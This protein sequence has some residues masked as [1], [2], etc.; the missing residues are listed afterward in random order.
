MNSYL[1][2]LLVGDGTLHLGKNW[3]YQVWID[4]H[5]KNSDIL[6]KAV[7]ILRNDGFNVWVYKVPGN[8]TRAA[9][10]AKRLFVEFAE[11]RKNPAE[12]F[13]HLNEN[14]KREFIAGFFDAEGT[15]TDRLVIY[16]GNIELLQAIEE[17]LKEL[18]I[19][20][21]TYRFGKILGIQIYQKKS[22]ETF[23]KNITCVK[24]SRLSG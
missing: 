15:V 11:I 23:V 10:C 12:H 20:C 14:E 1:T 8:K 22:R 7:E 24:I 5:N 13:L 16:N 2:G 4:Q 21:Y 3:K 19:V 18:G 17:F 9:V 6:R